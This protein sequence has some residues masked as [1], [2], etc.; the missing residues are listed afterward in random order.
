MEIPLQEIYLEVGIIIK[1]M[2]E[3]DLVRKEIWE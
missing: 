2:R 3:S 1:D